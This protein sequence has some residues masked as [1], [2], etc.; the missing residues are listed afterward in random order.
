[1]FC[2]V[3]AIDALNSAYAFPRFLIEQCE[4]GVLVFNLDTGATALLDEKSTSLIRSFMGQERVCEPDLRSAINQLWG[5]SLDYSV[6]LASLEESKL[7]SR[8]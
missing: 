5:D 8:C 7:V 4:G 6:I 2:L 3:G 1:M